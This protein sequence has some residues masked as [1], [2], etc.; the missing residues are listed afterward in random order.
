[1]N[2]KKKVFLIFG[3]AVIGTIAAFNANI[4]LRNEYLSNIALANIEALARSESG[5][6]NY[7]NGYTR[8]SGSKGGAYDCCQIWRDLVPH[9]DKCQ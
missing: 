9:D 2:M 4:G 7:V 3:L 6:C 5:D 1:M 8:F